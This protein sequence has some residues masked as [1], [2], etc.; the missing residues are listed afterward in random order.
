[1]GDLPCRGE[2][3]L[4]WEGGFRASFVI[5]WPG[6]IPQGQVLNVD[7]RLLSDFSLA[8]HACCVPSNPRVAAPG[9][10]YARPGESGERLPRMVIKRHTSHWTCS[11]GAFR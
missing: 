3:G 1:M 8:R 7:V 9:D 6:H 4:R 10:S 2:K 5:R 11:A